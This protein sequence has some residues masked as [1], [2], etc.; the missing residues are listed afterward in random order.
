MKWI[1]S[2]IAIMLI[3]IA[4]EDSPTDS[5]FYHNASVEGYV[6]FEE[7]STDTLS[8]TVEL[9]LNSDGEMIKAAQTTTDSDGYWHLDGLSAGEYSI[10]FFSESYGSKSLTIALEPN[11][12]ETTSTVV[13]EYSEPMEF[14]EITVDADS[15]DWGEPFYINNNA[16]DW[17]P[18][19][20]NCFYMAQNATHLFICVTG[21]FS[22]SDNTVNFYIDTDFGDETGVNDFST[23][24]GGDPGNRLRKTVT[25][26]DFFGADIGICNWALADAFCA[27]FSDPAA[28]DTN[29]LEIEVAMTASCIE[30]AIPFE[31]IYGA[32]NAPAGQSIGLVALIGGGGD[33]YFANDSIPQ[34]DSAGSFT[35]VIEAMLAN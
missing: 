27:S 28:I 13:F 21:Q 4:C 14:R 16:S 17:G 5:P 32:E 18:N 12:T 15:T 24:S 1:T 3:F 7:A 6:E 8:A 19:D 11:K 10:Y 25:A 2:I 30:I 33:Q 22:S 29:P 35:T 9:Y 23:L 34:W 20:F 26:P 31:Q